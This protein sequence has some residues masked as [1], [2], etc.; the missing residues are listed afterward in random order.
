MLSWKSKN[1]RR[2]IVSSLAGETLSMIG[3]SGELV[4]TKSVLREIFSEEIDFVPS[5]VVTDSKNLWESIHSTR[6]VDD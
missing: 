3:L 4:Y 5:I 6:L 1:L 2:K